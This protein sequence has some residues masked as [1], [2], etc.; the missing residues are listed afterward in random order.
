MGNAILN[1]IYGQQNDPAQQMS[2]WANTQ[3]ARNRVAGGMDLQ[4]NILPA[5]LTPRRAAR[6]RLGPDHWRA[7]GSDGGDGSRRSRLGYLPQ[8]PG[9]ECDQNAAEHG[10]DGSVALQR[11]QEAAAG[12][13][14]SIGL[15]MSA[16]ARPENRERVFKT[17]T[18]AR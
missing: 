3:Q 9:A 12:L 11:Q 16:F 13:Q 1:L 15:G 7:P 5:R 10:F 6:R 14:Q 2:D 4:G 17:F 8:M 18:S